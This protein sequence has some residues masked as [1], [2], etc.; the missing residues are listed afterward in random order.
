[1]NFNEFTEFMKQHIEESL[2][3]GFQDAN[4][5]VRVFPVNKLNDDYLGLSLAGESIKVTPTLN[6]N[7]LYEAY[8]EKPEWI[9]WFVD[10]ATNILLNET[11]DINFQELN[12]YESLKKH[13]FIRVSN[14]ERNSDILAHAPHRQIAGLAI[15]YHI[16]VAS[17]ENGTAT[18]LIKNDML[19]NLDIDEKQLHEDAMKNAQELAPAR[20]VPMSEFMIEN[21]LEEGMDP[22]F[23]EIFRHDAEATGKVD[24]FIVTTSK[25]VFEAAALF[26][27]GVMEQLSENYGTDLVIL[28]SSTHEFIVLPDEG[29][30]D[31]DGMKEMVSSINEAD[32]APSEQLADDVFHYDAKDKIFE[33]AEDFVIREKL[34]ELEG[35]PKG[36]VIGL[37]K[38]KQGAVEKYTPIK[39]GTDKFQGLDL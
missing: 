34:R 2:P 22:E 35:L 9:T 31:F 1:M 4:V 26:Y 17:D 16:M 36:S 5:E 6:L 14:A 21:M 32:V 38:L 13:L 30:R 18:A 20:I 8:N 33:R 29:E 24:P 7:A 12:D 10:Q 3:K 25:N 23:V 19:K 15:T 28:P 27:P 11:I 39:P 37:M